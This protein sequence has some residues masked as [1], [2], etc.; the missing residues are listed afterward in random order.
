[1]RTAIT[2]SK[3]NKHNIMFPFAVAAGF[4]ALGQEKEKAK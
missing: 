4:I 3:P 1:M 2:A